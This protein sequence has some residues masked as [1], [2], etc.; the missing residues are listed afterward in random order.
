MAIPEDTATDLSNYR[1]SRT[2]Q[3]LLHM[4]HSVVPSSTAFAVQ[5]VYDGLGTRTALIV[6][7]SGLKT[8]IRGDVT[9]SKSLSVGGDFFVT[10]NVQINGNVSLIGGGA[11]NDII[12]YEK[13]SDV[14]LRALS[15][16]QSGK[17]RI[18]D[19]QN[20]LDHYE[21]IYGNPNDS[22][23]DKNLFTLK[24]NN[25]S[26]NNFYIKNVYSDPDASCPLWIERAT[27]IVHI[28]TLRVVKITTGE[29]PTKPDPPIV[30]PR[31]PN[32]HR[33]EIIIGQIAMFAAL[34]LPEGWL[35]CDGKTYDIVTFPELF[36]KIGY[37]YTDPSIPSY[38][39]SVPDL[40]G[41]FVRHLDKK[42]K[43][44]KTSKNID[45]EPNRLIGSYQIDTY[46]SHFHYLHGISND[47]QLTY[48]NWIDA[49]SLP[50]ICIVNPYLGIIGHPYG[51]FPTPGSPIMF[52][53]TAVPY[54]VGIKG[55]ETFK[56]IAGG[57]SPGRTEYT[58]PIGDPSGLETRPKNIALIYAIKW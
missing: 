47:K 30:E 23:I 32:A 25:D 28:R 18:R 52:T 27:G 51:V 37:L 40:R 26:D 4:P 22:I 9:I 19:S 6:G 31:T 36:S 54:S 21:L 34:G 35:E 57:R 48:N 44:E 24:V 2:F 12:I 46:K 45:Q 16:V 41:L 11:I 56:D 7:G 49:V 50:S 55:G 15:T 17:L 8:D 58:P 53:G 39:F 5:Q 1:I 29:D 43:D 10:G 14:S 13:S 38:Q 33:H 3:G 20:T 42:R